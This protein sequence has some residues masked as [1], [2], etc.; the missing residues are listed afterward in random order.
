MKFDFSQPKV[1][2]ITMEGYIKKILDENNII[3]SAPTPAPTD[4]FEE[5]HSH[6]LPYHEQRRMHTLVA[7]LLYIS[8]RVRPDILLVVNFLTTK[9]NKFSEKD[10]KNVNRVLKYLFGTRTNIENYKQHSRHNN[11]NICRRILR[12][13]HKWKV[14]IRSMYNSGNRIYSI[15]IKQTKVNH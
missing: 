9:V 7:Q 14:P 4:L 3:E 10:K 13:S 6:L 11:H 12:N 2:S 8:I 5:Q 1:V 15:I